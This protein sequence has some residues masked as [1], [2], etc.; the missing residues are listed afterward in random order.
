M[1]RYIH[2]EAATDTILADKS[3]YS[4]NTSLNRRGIN[5]TKINKIFIS[6]THATLPMVTWIFLKALEVTRTVNQATG[7]SDKWEF[8]EDIIISEADQV[9]VGDAVMK[10]SG[11]GVVAY[12]KTIDSS[13]KMTL[14]S[15][16]SLTDNDV[17][18]FRDP[19]DKLTIT[20]PTI[21]P[22]VTFVYEYP[23]S[24]NLNRY[25]LMVKPSVDGSTPDA[26]IRIE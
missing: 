12:V 22:K 21:P 5:T 25:K 19:S 16:I 23:F 15:S 20:Y 24:F 6:N 13:K 1:S 2:I 9:K 10:S 14:N 7:S 11:G 3:N 18:Y 4:T 17:L 8:D 26:T